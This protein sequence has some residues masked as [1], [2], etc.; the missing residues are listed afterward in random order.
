VVQ[1]ATLT[2]SQPAP[3]PVATKPTTANQE[4][5]GKIRGKSG[6]SPTSV[7][8]TGA[9]IPRSQPSPTWQAPPRYTKMSQQPSQRPPQKSLLSKL[10]GW[11]VD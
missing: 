8:G 7:G 1:N 11:I 3:L 5:L 4:L 6:S 9:T 10:F 2:P